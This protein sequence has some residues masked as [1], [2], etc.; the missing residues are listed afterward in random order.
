MIWAAFCI[1]IYG[2]EHGAVHGVVDFFLSLVAN[3]C[4]ESYL[5]CPRCFV[6][7][8]I[9]GLE[10]TQKQLQLRPAE[11]SHSLALEVWFHGVSSRAVAIKTQINMQIKVL[12]HLLPS[13]L[14]H[15]V[16]KCIQCPQVFVHSSPSS[17]LFPTAF[18]W[19]QNQLSASWLPTSKQVWLR[20]DTKNVLGSVVSLVYRQGHLLYIVEITNSIGCPQ[21]I[22]S[23]AVSYLENATQC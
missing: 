15:M 20:E 23:S 18:L 2:Y 12:W 7:W 16:G 14:Q 3:L 11:V 17:L 21:I 6:V 4:A 5:P 8:F 19:L 9:K 22:S 1:R 13:L 10:D